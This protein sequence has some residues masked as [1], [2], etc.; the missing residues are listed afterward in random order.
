MNEFYVNLKENKPELN[1]SYGLEDRAQIEMLYFK[2]ENFTS[3]LVARCIH[4]FC[5]T[6]KFKKNVN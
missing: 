6:F 4:F 3:Q 5:D 1:P 2:A